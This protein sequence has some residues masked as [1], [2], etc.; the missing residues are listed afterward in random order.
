L[1]AA[2]GDQSPPSTLAP[3]VGEP[4]VSAPAF[5]QP[6]LLAGDPVEVDVEW[7]YTCEIIPGLEVNC[8][9]DY[10]TTLDCTGSDCDAPP[11]AEA[12]CHATL[13]VIPL[14]PGGSNGATLALTDVDT[15]DQR[16][17]GFGAVPVR[18]LDA[19]DL[20]CRIRS[21]DD[22]V[23]WCSSAP[24]PS[25]SAIEILTIGHAGEID[26]DL[27]MQAQSNL[28]PPDICDVDTFAPGELAAWSSLDGDLQVCTWWN[29]QPG[30]FAATVERDGRS[31]SVS[32]TV[33]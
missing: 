31:A 21:I 4:V 30:P 20:P 24:V 6:V 17:F 26:L 16:S 27:E 33:Q 2:C 28:G 12:T 22:T 9:R 18:S 32:L 29:V 1:L 19:I 3:R 11:P 15:G 5:D 13:D 8:C 23:T 14:D 25:G 10:D 7:D